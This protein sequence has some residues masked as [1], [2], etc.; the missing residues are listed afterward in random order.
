MLK[1]Y[2][3]VAVRSIFKHKVYSLIN[4]ASLGIGMALCLLIY[5]YV[6]TELSYDSFHNN[7]DNIYRIVSVIQEDSG[8][9]QNH[10]MT[11]M[12]L[13]PAIGEDYPEIVN[14]TRF[15][16]SSAAVVKVDNNCFTERLLYA[17]PGMLSIFSFPLTSGNSQSA[18]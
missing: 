8:Q 11:P 5:Q 16:N 1:N 2:L 3:K 17:D 4:L 10:A 6:T 15:T 14:F 7:R 12:P 13:G 9:W 18:L